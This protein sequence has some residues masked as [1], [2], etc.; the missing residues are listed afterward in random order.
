MWC[1]FFNNVCV[2]TNGLMSYMGWWVRVIYFVSVYMCVCTLARRDAECVHF[3]RTNNGR[4]VVKCNS[5]QTGIARDRR[6]HT[7]RTQPRGGR[8]VV[9]M[10][11]R[12]SQLIEARQSGAEN[13]TVCTAST[14]ACNYVLHWSLTHTLAHHINDDYTQKH[15]RTPL[16]LS[17]YVRDSVNVWF[18]APDSRCN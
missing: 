1:V 16:K 4:M 15:A 18:L 14:S 10:A 7:Q 11:T 2:F 17:L 6:T 13:V 8:S 9:L 3:I 12:N 5:P